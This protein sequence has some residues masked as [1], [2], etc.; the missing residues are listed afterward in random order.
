MQ[1]QQFQPLFTTQ[2]KMYQFINFCAYIRK[3]NKQ[4]I[5]VNLL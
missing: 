3:Q 4:H 2:Q 1:L 5:K